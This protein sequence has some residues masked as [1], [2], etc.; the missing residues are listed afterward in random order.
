M[1]STPILSMAA[2]APSGLLLPE[3]VLHTPGFALLSAFVAVNTVVFVAL[4][5]VKMLPA[6]PLSVLLIHRNRRGE[7]R[8]IYPDGFENPPAFRSG[9]PGTS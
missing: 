7:N 2:D 6:L 4:A 5:V 9:A 8:T 3:S 1:Q